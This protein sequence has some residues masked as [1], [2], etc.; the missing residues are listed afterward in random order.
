MVTGGSEAASRSGFGCNSPLLHPVSACYAMNQPN[1]VRSRFLAELNAWLTPGLLYHCFTG[2][3]DPD[4]LG[5]IERLYPA[6]QEPLLAKA[7]REWPARLQ[8]IAAERRRQQVVSKQAVQQ[9]VL[10]LTPQRNPK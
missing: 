1:L 8:A 5:H 7:E 10:S 9:Y 6:L 3:D 4:R 2:E